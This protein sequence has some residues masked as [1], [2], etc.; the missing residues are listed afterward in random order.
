MSEKRKLIKKFKKFFRLAK[1]K[2]EIENIHKMTEEERRNYLRLNPKIFTNK[3]FLKLKLKN[4]IFSK[5]KE[6]TNFF[7][8]ITIEVFSF[9][10]KKMKF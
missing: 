3:V 2:L 6:N 8:S 1:E 4:K 10:M 5:T 9:W 7:K